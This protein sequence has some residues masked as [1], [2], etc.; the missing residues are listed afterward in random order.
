[1]NYSI[2]TNMLIGSCLA[3]HACVLYERLGKQEDFIFSR[4]YC[5]SCGYEL[6]LLDEIPILSYLLLKGKCRYCKQ[7]IP[8]YLFFY[9]LLG[10]ISFSKINFSNSNG[11]LTALFFFCLLIEAIYDEQEQEFPLFFLLI[12]SII[13]LFTKLTSFFLWPDIDKII[14]LISSLIFIYFIKKK[15]MG[16]GDYLIY[17][18][19]ALYFNLFFANL[20]FLLACILSLSQILFKRKINTKS[21]IPFVPYIYIAMIIIYLLK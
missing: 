5:S 7:T 19:I 4:S 21:E 12:P 17:L 9:E 2:F 1:M 10:A 8:A 11:I 14:L 20:T 18:L 16:T 6:N 3:S 13:I 15:E